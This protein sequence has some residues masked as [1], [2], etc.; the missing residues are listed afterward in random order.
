MKNSITIGMSIVIS[1]LITVHYADGYRSKGT[2][3][4]VT[5]GCSPV[6]MNHTKV[7]VNAIVNT[8]KSTSIVGSGPYMSAEQ[9]ERVI[10]NQSSKDKQLNRKPT[11]TETALL[12]EID[13]GQYVTDETIVTVINTWASYEYPSPSTKSKTLSTEQQFPNTFRLMNAIDPVVYGRPLLK[14][15][16][17]QIRASLM[18][19]CGDS[20]NAAK[21]LQDAVD[22]LTPFHLMVDKNRMMSLVEE[23]EALYASGA[24]DLAQ[25]CFLEALSYDWYKVEDPETLQ[26]LRALYI[27][28]GRGLIDCRRQN[29]PALEE[30]VFVPAVNTEL[31][32]YLDQAILNAGGKPPK[33]MVPVTNNPKE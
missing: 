13:S 14:G 27:R 18:R 6:L 1:F 12:K 21:E 10:M 9:F 33:R 26:T 23:G 2:F 20:V 30:I 19:T 32:P 24:K 16:L 31:V 15:R 28:A 17:H 11:D 7:T 22:V 5:R 8:R 29:L 25:V 4:V 3:K